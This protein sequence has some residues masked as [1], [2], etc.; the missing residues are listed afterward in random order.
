MAKNEGYEMSCGFKYGDIKA[1]N[2]S[3]KNRRLVKYID[4]F[5]RDSFFK[6]TFFYCF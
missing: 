3:S 5:R 1:P 4:L 2:Q 6:F